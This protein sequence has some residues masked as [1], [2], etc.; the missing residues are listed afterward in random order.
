MRCKLEG[1]EFPDSEFERT[2]EF[3]F[4]HHRGLLHTIDGDLI[5]TDLRAFPVPPSPA[6]PAPQSDNDNPG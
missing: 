4:V 3:G 5:E 1:K 6:F 2:E